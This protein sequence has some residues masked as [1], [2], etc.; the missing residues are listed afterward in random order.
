VYQLAAVLLTVN[1]CA[2][3]LIFMKYFRGFCNISETGWVVMPYEVC[4]QAAFF[5]MWNEYNY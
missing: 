2:Q 4:P 1:I 3:L 5:L